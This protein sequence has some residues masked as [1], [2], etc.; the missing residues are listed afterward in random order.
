MPLAWASLK[1]NT[2]CTVHLPTK[3][4]RNLYHPH[5]CLVHAFQANCF[6]YVHLLLYVYCVCVC[7]CVCDVRVR[8]R[9]VWLVK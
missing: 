6:T 3:H 9:E 7:V 1:N 8:L 5:R 2:P 4:A